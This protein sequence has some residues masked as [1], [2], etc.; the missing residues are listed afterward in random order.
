MADQCHRRIAEIRDRGSFAQELGI[1]RHTEIL[2]VLLSR[3]PLQRRDDD[4]VGRAGQHGAANDDD[5]V[6]GFVFE[7]LADLLADAFQVGEVETAVLPAW[8][9]D[10]DQRQVGRVNGVLGVGRGTQSSICGGLANQLVET[11]LDD[12]ASSFVQARDLVGIDVHA[13]N[14]M[15]VSRKRSRRNTADVP[16]SKHRNLH[17][18]SYLNGCSSSTAL[19]IQARQAVRRAA[20]DR[21]ARARPR[22]PLRRPP[23][24]TRSTTSSRAALSIRRRAL[25]S[26]IRCTTAWANRAGS[27][28]IITSRPLRHGQSFGA[29][30]G[31][32]Y[33]LR[34]RHRLENLQPRAAPDPERDDVDVTLG[35]MWPDVVDPAG[36][37]DPM[38]L[39]RGAS[40]PAWSAADDAQRDVR[41]RPGGCAAGC[42]GRN[43][44]SRPRSAASPSTR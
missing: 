31:R 40:P 20:A 44:A 21:V 1:D 12:R 35:D 29:D 18:L 27:S 33:R 24:R 9:A 7:H 36:D 38:L 41:L 23:N 37:F 19:Y 16:K 32:Y 2:A 43:R 17:Q 4:A 6:G 28:A 8:R 39:G 34:H 3:G 42:R 11:L 14:R 30:G 25:V 26:R 13:D 10:A 5:V 15:T 22:N